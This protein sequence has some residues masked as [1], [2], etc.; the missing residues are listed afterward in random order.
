MESEDKW[1]L[2]MELLC[3]P[4][5]GGT[6]AQ[7]QRLSSRIAA[8]CDDVP[9]HVREL[10]NL[11]TGPHRERD[12]H[13]WVKKKPWRSLLP[14]AYNFP[15]PYTPDGIRETLAEHSAFLPHELMASLS[16]VPELFEELL[17]GPPDTLASFWQKTAETRWYQQ[18][19]LPELHR[20][21][22]LCVPIGLHG[23]DA[24]VFGAQKMLVLTWGSVAREL[25]TLDG[26]LLF[27][28][29]TYAHVVPG[30][31]IE[32]LYKILV[33]SLNSMAEGCWPSVD[34]LGQHFSATHHPRRFSKAGLPLCLSGHRGVWSELRGDWKW[35]VEALDFD[36]WYGRSFI[37]HLCR[38]HQKIPRLVYTQFRRNAHIR[39]TKVS[40]AAFRDWYMDRL[41]RPELSRIVG[42]DIWRC[43]ADAMHCLDL[44]IYQS[45]AASCLFDLVAEGV[46]GA[47]N[48]TGFVLAHV[49]YKV[50][51]RVN[52]HLPCPRFDKSK[53]LPRGK[54]FPE[55]TQ[56]A[57]KAS[58]TRYLMRWLR[59][60][61][62]QPGVSVGQHGVVRLAMMENFVIFEDVCERNTRW[63]SAD[64][65]E[66]CAKSMECA[67]ICMNALCATSL[68]RNK[69]VWHITPKCHM[70]THLAYD[71]AASGVNPR[72]VTCYSDEDMIGRVKRIVQRCHGGSAGRRG[73]QRYAI[74]VGTRWWKRLAQLRGLLV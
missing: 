27:S 68:D 67:L 4:A 31:T 11:P 40:S 38:A 57:A 46:W 25:L 37:C 34:H 21:P 1:D 26:R 2:E 49:D 8:A 72:R 74:L 71:F 73:L 19:P 55:F 56:Q 29:V 43:W 66:S 18:H 64:D 69:F 39:R 15:I 42:F 5:T 45:V 60:V 70:A 3:L 35:Q 61:L 28:V 50:W 44:G 7:M 54:D 53:L 32:T 24:G 23:D 10:A 16:L 6:C 22:A 14:D 9:A 17:I 30:K 65:R 58:M 12:L 47:T 48:E 59:S 20:D 33:W 41:V 13:R 36:Q 52:G 62:D 63:L 51:C